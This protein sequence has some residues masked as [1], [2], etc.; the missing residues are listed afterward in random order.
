VY[1]VKDH[2]KSQRLNPHIGDP[3]LGRSCCQAIWALQ[4][5]PCVTVEAIS[6]FLVAVPEKELPSQGAVPLEIP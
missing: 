4:D 2:Q 5:R 3:E 6:E 1:L